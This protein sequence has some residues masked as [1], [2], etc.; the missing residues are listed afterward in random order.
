MFIGCVVVS[1]CACEWE[2]M[3]VVCALLF[4]H[5]LCV[6]CVV[7]GCVYARMS[8]SDHACGCVCVCVCY[9]RVLCVHF[10]CM[11]CAMCVCMSVWVLCVRVCVGVLYVCVSVCMGVMCVCVM[12]V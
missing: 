10:V 2:R 3:N 7:F 4:V 6:L 12:C 5:V 1:A 11:L 8:C 9:V